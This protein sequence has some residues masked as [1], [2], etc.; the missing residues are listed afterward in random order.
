MLWAFVESYV[1]VTFYSVHQHMDTSPEL[2]Q[3]G[4]PDRGWEA[5][6]GLRG[7]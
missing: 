7:H 1:L 2:S 4:R 3:D 6:S 5:V